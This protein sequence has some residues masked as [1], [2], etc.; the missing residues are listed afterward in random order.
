MTTDE[1]YSAKRGLIFNIQSFSI[2]D[3]PGI[4]T[5]V[6]LKG[7]PLRCRWCSNP[8][9]WHDYPEIVTNDLKCTLCGRCQKGCPLSAIAVDEKRRAVNRAIC[10]SCLKCADVCPTGAIAVTGRYMNVQD[11]MKEVDSD[12]LFYQNS[13]GGV[14]LSGG[15]PLMQPELAVELLRECK[16]RGFHTAIETCG[17]AP[18]SV[19]DRV[20]DFTDLALYDV[21]HMDPEQ[22]RKGTGKSNRLILEN[23][24]KTATRVRTWLRLPLITGFND[25]E[26][27]LTATARFGL[28]IGVEKASL[29]PYH[30]WGKGKYARLGKR[31]P[32]GDT[33]TLSDEFVKKCQTIMETMGLKTT[34]GR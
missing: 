5:T 32:M 8:E 22:H 2:H 7:C 1:K 12:A 10:D 29:L 30:I 6:F 20:L 34:I 25:T 23:A 16:S 27:N 28:E 15:E 13:G 26:D 31:Y 21:K 14:T 18:W 33:P 24:R 17:Y 19:L 9:S 4:R 3:G 11:V